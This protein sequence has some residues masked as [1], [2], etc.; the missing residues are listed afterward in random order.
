[1]LEK[2]YTAVNAPCKDDSGEKSERKDESYRGSLR[3]LGEGPVTQ[4]VGRST[5]SEV[6]SDVA[7]HRMRTGAT[8]CW[9]LEGR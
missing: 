1:M 4:E 6:H 8:C 9:E 3:L 2:A 5:D 7:S